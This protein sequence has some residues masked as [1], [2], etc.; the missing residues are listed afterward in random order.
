MDKLLNIILK[1][2]ITVVGIFMIAT[3][4]CTIASLFVSVNYDLMDYLPDDAPSTVALNTMDEE[5]TSGTPNARVMLCD[6]SVSDVLKAK[7]LISQVDGVNDVTW[8]DDVVNVYQP[9]EFIEKKTLEEYYIDGNALLT[10]TIDTDKKVEAIDAVREI[11]GNDAS[12]S[13]S[14]VDSAA[15]VKLTNNEIK[16]IMVFVLI[17]IFIILIITTTSY[18]EPVLFLI[19]IG[20]AIML[21]RGTNLIMGEISFVT[22]AAGSVLQLAV[23]MDYSIFLLD[24]FAECRREYDSVEDAMRIAVK[25]SFGS[26]MSSGL[27]TVMGFVALIFMKFK[28]GPDMGIVMA[29]SIALSLF[30]VMLFLPSAALI[31]YKLIDRTEHKPFVKPLHALGDIV[32]KHR[33]AILAVFVIITIPCYLAQS[34]N[35]FTY[36]Q[37]GI[38]GAGTQVGDDTA[39]IEKVFGKS[40]LMALMVPLDSQYKEKAL[41]E[42]LLKMPL[43]T[44]VISYSQA[45]GITIPVEFLPQDT[46]SDLLSDNHSR[47]VITIDADTEGSSAFGVVDDIRALAAS[48]YG[49]KYLLVGETVNSYDLKDTV[50]EDNKIVNMLSILSIALILFLNFKSVSIPVILLMVIESSIWINLAVPYFQD[51]TLFY[52]GYLI[53]S[54][55]QL[56]ATVDYAILFADRYIENRAKMSKDDAARRTIT[57]TSLSIL[58]S[59]SILTFAGLMLGFISTNGVISQLG[60]LVGRGAIL[61][62]I[63]VLLVLPGLIHLLDGVIY[64]TTKNLDFYQKKP[65]KSKCAAK[66]TAGEERND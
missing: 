64:K 35:S 27:T 3:I 33:R 10:L 31:S 8:L 60:I 29:K 1:H 21:N 57:D 44:S 24:R 12:M 20:V 9:F 14:A 51:K 36:G 43:V 5:Y 11:I 58:T 2:R 41:S 62:C 7:E 15:A 48:Y 40:N 4:I 19:T 56:G 54:S 28:I 34:R 25:K 45:A 49:D 6:V 32:T 23:S 61:S 53:I 42:D 30:T 26:V 18:F 52:I 13:G 63:L 55:I 37:S 39:K 66:L 47:L 65:A 50:T 22:N 46:I 59:A 16:K 17:I 38:Y